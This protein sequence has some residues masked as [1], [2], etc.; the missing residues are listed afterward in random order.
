MKFH[1][2]M[3]TFWQPKHRPRSLN[4]SKLIDQMRLGLKVKIYCPYV[5]QNLIYGAEAFTA[6]RSRSCDA[7]MHLDAVVS[8]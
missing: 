2:T 5:L 4:L 3:K 7:L 8:D 6:H 1:E